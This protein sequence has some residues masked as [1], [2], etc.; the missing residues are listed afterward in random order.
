[1]PF[2]PL[3]IRKLNADWSSEDP[4]VQDLACRTLAEALHLCL[5]E[6]RWSVAN[7]LFARGIDEELFERA[8]EEGRSYRHI[9]TVRVVRDHNRGK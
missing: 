2:I 5:A 3:D 1:M 6:A 7:Q 4:F 8:V 9:E